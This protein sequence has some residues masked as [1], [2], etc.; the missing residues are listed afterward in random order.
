MSITLLPPPNL[1][2][3]SKLVRITIPSPRCGTALWRMIRA[4]AGMMTQSKKTLRH[5]ASFEL[6]LPFDQPAIDRCRPD[7]AWMKRTYLPQ[8]ANASLQKAS[9]VGETVMSLQAGPVM[10][11]WR[12]TAGAYGGTDAIASARPVRALGEYHSGVHE[13][14]AGTHCHPPLSRAISTSPSRALSSNRVEAL[15]AIKAGRREI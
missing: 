15:C 13:A 12:L 14:P 4:S 10:S 1:Q 11:A 3:F 7:T 8:V 9:T 2:T 5:N 6:C